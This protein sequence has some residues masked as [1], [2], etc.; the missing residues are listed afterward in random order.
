MET[1]IFL[2]GI[3]GPIILAIGAGIFISRGFYLRI[4]RD[5]EKE[6][7]AVLIFAMVA[8]AVGIWQI[9]AH[10]AWGSLAEILISF[11]GWA[12]LFKGLMFALFPKF[13]DRAGDWAAK[14]KLVPWA[15][16]LMLVIGAYLSWLAYF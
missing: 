11:L 15:G 2:A 8:M 10:N 16:V 13:I 7:L 6:T 1:T 14:S 3:W 12:L 9:G 5:L 4:Y